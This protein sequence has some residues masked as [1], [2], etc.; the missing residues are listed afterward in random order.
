MPQQPP[1]LPRLGSIYLRDVVQFSQRNQ[2]EKC[3][4]VSRHCNR[5]LSTTAEGRLPKRRFV[6]HVSWVSTHL[7]MF[8]FSESI[9]ICICSGCADMGG[10]SSVRWAPLRLSDTHSGEKTSKEK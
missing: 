10:E 9:C 6:M 4:V 8:S 1:I 7:A 5:V 3:R 2:I